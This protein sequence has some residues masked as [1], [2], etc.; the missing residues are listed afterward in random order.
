VLL[1]ALALGLYARIAWPW[2]PLGW[3]ALVPWLA[4]LDR[5]TSWRALLEAA[6]LM[7]IA[8]ELAAF[9]WFA[10]AIETYTRIPGAVTVVLLVLL[11]PVLQPQVLA[12][13]LARHLARWRGASRS[14]AA[15][16]G[17]FA[18]VGAEWACPKLFGDTLGY[19]L[20]PSAWM[21]QAA[22]V[23]GVPGL[24][25]VLLLGNECALAALRALARGARRRALA[26]AAGLA[27]LVLTLLGYGALRERTLAADAGRPDAVRA[28]IVQADIAR[29]GRLAAENG[30]FAA[31]RT[32][33]EA[34]F[35]LS[36]KLLRRSPL[37]LIVWP[38]T[39][40]PTTF[41]SPKSAA[42]AEFDRDIARFVARNGIPL[43]FG[44][45]DAE[46]GAEFNAAVFLEPA[47]R[48]PLEFETYRKASLF[49]LTERVPDLL[50]GESVRRWLPWMGTWAPG[51]GGEA[52]RLRLRDGRTLRVAPL[53]CY[54]ALA[55]ALVRQAVRDGAEVIVTLS[56]D[57]WF[58]DGPAPWLH[59]VG[60]AFRSIETRRP[61]LRA[62][63]TGISAVI[64]AGGAIVARTDV[65][66]R[67]VLAAT[68]TPEA[69][70][71]TLVLRWGA[72]LGPLALAL[73]VVLVAAPLASAGGLPNS[74][75][76]SGRR[77][78]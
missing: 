12:L 70:A 35:A 77:T 2:T 24:T 65:D 50:G 13:A 20:W 39:V 44:A 38:E 6:L 64:D 25:L 73:G 26:P 46:G 28:G 48:G 10:H 61:Q 32:I 49:P 56:N 37:D 60:A 66:R 53:I 21:R 57:G 41:G 71:V 67:A 22:D 69:H 7:A 19:G 8:F 16:A 27:A 1:S 3:V 40:Y 43:V 18:W 62:T 59:L 17:T 15:L 78:P 34:H 33:L 4:V 58:A 36:A 76:G 9:G 23:A 75:A 63:N 47:A 14:R 72:W 42:G 31:V 29:Y 5:T 11:A 68:V 55:P 30:T 74:R 51:A 45:Y 52:V 54:D